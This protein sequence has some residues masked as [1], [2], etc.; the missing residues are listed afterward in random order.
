MTVLSGALASTIDE[1]FRQRKLEIDWI[2]F[3]MPRY[4]CDTNLHIVRLQM[5]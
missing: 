4:R 2:H 1:E 3:V 5:P